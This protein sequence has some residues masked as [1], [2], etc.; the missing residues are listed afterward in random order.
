MSQD[1]RD[2]LA[3]FNA[4]GVENLV[5]GAHA[6]AAHGYV[7]ATKVLNVWVRP[8]ADNAQRAFDALADFRAPLADLSVADLATPGLIFQIGVPPVRNSM[9]NRSLYS[10]RI[11]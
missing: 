5:V 6:L 3:A 7:R 1:F 2:L 10:P 11:T 4:R 9:A 8:D